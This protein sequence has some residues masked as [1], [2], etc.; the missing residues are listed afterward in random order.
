MSRRARLS[1]ISLL[2]WEPAYDLLSAQR[3]QARRP[4]LS[5]RRRNSPS[6]RKVTPG[7]NHLLSSSG[8]PSANSPG[9]NKTGV[10]TPGGVMDNKHAAD[11][12]DS[13]RNTMAGWRKSPRWIW[14]E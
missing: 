3:A 2:R 12:R 13:P 7:S 4:H 10:D 1:H 6:T 5:H 8:L 14:S 9:I 11:A